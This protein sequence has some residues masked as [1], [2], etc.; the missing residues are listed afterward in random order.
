MLSSQHKLLFFELTAPSP[1]AGSGDEGSGGA[2]VFLSILVN[3][4]DFCKTMQNS[5]D[6][7]KNCGDF[8]KMNAK[9]IK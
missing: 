5:Y 9:V 3:T 8:S 4:K 2:R 6:F 7:G 1:L